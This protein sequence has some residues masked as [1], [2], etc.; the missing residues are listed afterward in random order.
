MISEWGNRMEMT[1]MRAYGSIGDNSV[2]I[3]RDNLAPSSKDGKLS[4]DHRHTTRRIYN[5]KARRA[6]NANLRREMESL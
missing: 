3:H 2:V 4:S 6:L 5:H 1:N